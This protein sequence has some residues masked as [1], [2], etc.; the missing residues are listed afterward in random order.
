[1]RPPRRVHFLLLALACTV[2][3]W[4]ALRSPQP[5]PTPQPT[6]RSE[7]AQS[8][9]ASPAEAPSPAPP[10]PTPQAPAKPPANTPPQPAHIAAQMASRVDS[11][12]SAAFYHWAE[13]YL[14]A[15]EHERAALVEEGRQLAEARRPELRAVIVADPRKA[16][17]HAV[18]MVLRQNLPPAVLERLEDRH[19]AIGVLRVLQGVPMAGDP[20][21]PRSLT[22]R[23]VE[24]KDGGTY[25]AYVYGRRSEV[26]TW[27]ANASLNGISIDRQLALNENPSRTLEVGE[28]PPPEKPSVTI[29]PVSGLVTPGASLA[30]GAPITE[31]TPAV[32]TATQIVQL[33]GQY[34]VETYNQTILYGEGVTGGSLGFTGI[35]PAAPTP[36][37]GVVRVLA[38]PMTYADQNGVPST[39][40]ALYNVLRDVGDFYAKASFG[41]LTLVGTVTPP[42]KLAHN[43][44]WYVNR[45]TTNGGDISGTSL[46]HSHARDEARKLGFDSNN[47]DCIVVRHNGGPGSYGGLAGGSTVWMRSDSTGTWAHEIGHCFGLGHSNSWDTAGTSAIGAGTNLEYGDTY[48]I[49]GNSGSFPAGHYNAQAKSQIKW[50]PP[51]FIESIAQSGQYR[52]YAFDQ[53]VL[54]PGRRYALTVTKDSQKTYWGELRSLFDTNPWAKNGVLLGWRYPNGSGSNLQRI[55]VTPGSPFSQSDAPIAVGNTFSDLETGIHMTTIAVNDTPRY[56]DVV[57]NFGDFS[58]NRPP[59]LSLTASAEVVPLGATV[60]FTASASDPDNDA[61]AYY[62][63]HFGDTSVKLVS[64]N[65]PVITRTFSTAGSYVVSC[66]VSDMKGGTSTRSRLITVGTGNS[67][68]TISGRITLMG[69]GL[70]DVV[71]TA[72]GSNGVVTDAD[73]SYSIP[74]L[75]ANTYTMTPLLYGYSFGELFN[76]SIT[77]SP[78]A[79]GADFEASPLP[80]VTIAA[81]IPTA[82]ELAPVTTGRFT[83]T[84]TGDTTQSLVVNV[85]TALGSATKTSDYTLSPD[86]V[87]ASQGFS[88]FTIPA[89]SATL[90]I[91]VTPV[92]DTSAE[93]PETVILQLGPGNGY[94]VGKG[95]SATVVIEDDDTALPKISITATR[96]TTQEGSSQQGL[97]TITR[98]GATTT[99]LTVLYSVGGTATAGADYTTL[100]GTL[101][102]PAGSASA[103]I[104]VVPVDDTISEPLETISLTLSTNAAYL[105]DPLAT[106]ATVNL[107]DNDLQ[108][109][110]VVATD[111]TATEVDLTVPGAVPDT[112]TFVITRSGDTSN[113]LT[114]YYAMT[115]TPSTGVAALHGV[116]YE[117]LP[118]S[119]IIPAGSTQASIT[120]LPR[121]DNM[122]EGPESVVLSLGAGTT[123]YVLGS[124][125]SATVTINDAPTD[126]PT[127]DVVNTSSASEPSTT[128]TFRITVRGGTGTGTLPIAF[129]LG[130]TATFTTDYTVTGTG[131]TSTGTSV[132][133]S[134]GATV[135]KDV[136]ITP[137]NDTTAEELETIILT[138]TP[139]AS[140]TTY[141][142]TSS[143][144]MWLKDDDQPTVFVDT[145]VGTSGSSTVTEGTTSTPT[146]F[147]VSR[148]G[149]TTAALVVN[150]TIGGT[151]TAG[152]DYTAL[153]GTVTIA[154]GSLGADVPVVITNDTTF[155]GVETITFDF[156]PGAYARGPGAV[157]YIADNETSTQTVAF[158]SA[159]ASG[160]E[161]VATVNIPVTLA[162][163]ATQR[164]TVEYAADSGTRSAVTATATVSPVPYWLRMV[165][166][167]TSFTSYHSPDGVTWTQLG[168]AQTI[169]MSSTSYLA[170]LAVTSHV[171][172]TLC[173]VV[174]DNVTV[175]GLANGGTQGASSTA[176]IGTV[177]ATGSATSSSGTYSISG[178]GADITGTGDA[179]RYLW[180]PIT[181]STTCTLTARV[182]SQTNTNTSARAAVMI[183]EST[184]TGSMHAMTA[185]MPSN[186]IG[187]F[188]RATTN[189]TATNPSNFT[190]TSRPS[191]LR[192]DRAGDVF[193]TSISR[194]GVSWAQ[195]GTPQTLALPPT[196]LA[197][198]AVSAKSDGSFTTATFDQLTLNGSTAG[199]LNGR[200]IGFV[201]EEGSYS[202]SNGVHTVVGSGAGINTSTQDECYFPAQSVTGDFS[203]AARIT[204]LTGGATTAQ[205]GIMVREDD[206]YR[207][208][209]VYIG[210]V[211]TAS[212]ESIA[213][214]TS[215][216]TAFGSGVDFTLNAGTL[217]FEVGEQTKNITLSITDD[218]AP[219]PGDNIVLL[220]RNPTAAI[221]GAL[222]QF[223]YTIIDND[224][225]TSTPFVAF[226][227]GTS[228][229]NESDGSAS[230]LVSLS[231][232]A[233]SIITVAYATANGSATAGA[234]YQAAAGTLSFA[235]GETLKAIPAIPILQDAVSEPDETLLVTLSNPSGAQLG[236]ITTHTLTINDDDFPTVNLTASDP[237]A[238]EAGDTGTFT[239]ARTGSLS[240]ALSVG[241]T[242]SGTATSGT[243]YAAIATPGTVL[244]PDGQATATVT[245]TPIQ[246]TT[247]EGTETVILTLS[248][249]ASNYKLGTATSATVSIADDDRSTV[250]IVANIPLASEDAG[251]PGQFTITRT[252]PLGVALTV[253][254]TVSGTATSTTDYTTSPTTIT[255]L[256]FSAG[257]ASRTIDILPVDD[258]L[259]EPSE[260]VTISLGTGSYDIGANSFASVEITDNDAQ[261]SLF[262][263]GP[264]AQGALVAAGNGVMLSATVADDGKPQPLT[265]AWTQVA[266]PGTATFDNAAAASTGVTFDLPGTY[267]L[268][269]SATDGQFTVS[270][271]TTVVVGSAITAADWVTQDLGTSSSRRGQTLQL[272]STFSL[273]GTGA[274]YAATTN[275]QAHVALRSIDGDSSIVTRLTSLP[276]TTG[277]A[278]VTIRDAMVR[279]AR[280]AVLGYVPGTG[281]QFRTRTAVTT[282]D[283]VVTQTGLT[284]PLW[285]KLERNS[286][287]GAITASYAPDS[288]GAP[289]TWTTLGTPTVITMDTRANVGLTTTSNSTS[290]S[291][292]AT[293]DNVTLTPTPA[294]PALIAEDAAATPALAGN[295]SLTAGT[296]T[297]AGS[298]NGY[299][300]AWQYSGDLM[301]TAKHA[302][303]T[304]SAGSATSGIRIS[305]NI[306]GGAYAQVGRIP[307]GSYSG[308]LWRSVAGGTPAG[309]PSFTGATRW[310]RVIRKGN[311]ITAFH[312]ADVSG[313]P[314]T[315]TQI[316][317]PQTVIMTT[318][319]LV[320]F[321]VDNASGV[322]LNTV[323]FSNLSIVPLNSA[324][325][326][327]IQSLA[328]NAPSPVALDGTVT[329][330]NYPT[331][332]NL[333]TLWSQR[334][335]PAT[336]RF[337]SSTSVDSLANLPKT[338]SYTVRLAADDG[339]I[340]SFR[341]LTLTGIGDAA[342][343]TAPSLGAMSIAGSE[344]TT[345]TF[346][347][348]PFTT[349]YSDPNGDALFSITI[350]SLP[351]T[352]ILKF[353]GTAVTLNQVIPIANIGNLTYTP[354]LNEYGAK[355]FTLTAFDG[356]ASS[357]PA[358][359]TMNIAAVN[360]VPTANTRFLTTVE[361]TAYTGTLTGFDIE[362]DPLTFS[363]ATQGS[364]G[365]ATITN[366]ATGAFIYTPNP[367]ANGSDSFTFL[368]NDGTATSAP[369]T[370]SV[371]I[372]PVNDAPLA[373]SRPITIPEDTTFTGTLIGSDVDGDAISFS[374]LTQPSKG[375]AVITNAATGDFTYT[376]NPNANGS[377]SFTFLVSDGSLTSAPATVSFTIT[378]VNDTPV[379]NAQPI[380]TNEDTAFT[381]TLTGSDIDGDPLTFSVVTQGTKGTVAITDTSTGAFTYTPNADANGSDSFTFK[382]NDGTANSAPATVSVTITPVNDAPVANPRSITTNENTAF[383]GFLTGSDAESDP[384]TFSIVT[385]GSKGTV[386]IRK[387]STG[388]FTYTPNPNAYGS[389]SFTFEIT[390]GTENSATATVAVTITPAPSRSFSGWSNDA[391]L[392]DS[393]LMKY[394]I[395]GAA[396]PEATGQDPITTV[397]PTAF[398]I[399]AV[400]RTNSESLTVVAEAVSALSDYATPSSTLTIQGIAAADQ[401]G[402]PGGCQRQIFTANSTGK[403]R[404]FLRLKV[405]LAP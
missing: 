283:T 67:R 9:T 93:G 300:H 270:D 347:P 99:A 155:E 229:V 66:T 246:D 290:A 235:P 317:Q 105:I 306:E 288:A 78:S 198:F 389:D 254:L 117:A 89:D 56:A 379:A 278:G 395:G 257:Q 333:T 84:R 2:V 240:G 271:Q 353:S 120:I 391:T 303:A 118:G 26:V 194:D 46:E 18:P 143:A 166:N 184:A 52:L 191:W 263:T 322:G 285:L 98:T 19:N 295:S 176:D 336:I 44:A 74:N 247:N 245:V 209:M 275:D 125:S 103:T 41:R 265:L 159:G 183:R 40:A 86:Y 297:V 230:V 286:T 188:A 79:S 318:P 348:T 281:L 31:E 161:S 403:A 187:I 334:A 346:T 331:P 121:F 108:T 212:A 320:G 390:D 202:L 150:Y 337:S 3:F 355:T 72:N 373:T 139:S 152:S 12:A 8:T 368:A 163:P 252:E 104:S 360:D 363:I 58:S 261:P 386:A 362:G 14:S 315:W 173:A 294:A 338:G 57:V 45:D 133:L 27:T 231:R 16:L 137:V 369:G 357:T 134:N 292:T 397:T 269:L 253:N 365:I 47:Y 370:V 63:Q 304:S 92:V 30:E 33:C 236:A 227:S 179:F 135:T 20:T 239:F 36:A 127:V 215:V 203:I 284:L 311:S 207:G 160:L 170:G 220:L 175:T 219:E 330:D 384:L 305:E 321:W 109:I 10:Q 128:G 319:V 107:I 153:S 276:L 314:G 167:G 237:N 367:N 174:F 43:E 249:S 113:P 218:N 171:A 124:P 197:G 374:L 225:A 96:D 38:I 131:N 326:V 233:S 382:T 49:M 138:L 90:D 401:S 29:C 312:A 158:Q 180:F 148:T 241:F 340:Q 59:T 242:R 140:Y 342:L 190:P 178:A 280:R 289:G 387:A 299:F 55:D 62:W 111:P 216:S 339:S 7:I 69:V 162:S 258:L 70:P 186:S 110:T 392:T 279:S 266:G 345:L 97:F 172:G 378:P 375:I 260:F 364:K 393:L 154:A 115:G 402:V 116:D 293:F 255:T 71:V 145:Q 343:N 267:I 24:F 73:G 268:Q 87:N 211:S 398:T 222:T 214:T 341:D 234:D 396:T 282:N 206:N 53:G 141:P 273:T 244:I 404:K 77:V 359:L 54:V 21:P 366:A 210:S 119:V 149:S 88:T 213:R 325:V 248:A 250:S 399:T 349:A 132:T 95:S 169:S 238:N 68:Y 147:Y 309:V 129:T 224:A 114:V 83:L 50:L 75:S 405:Q 377:D 327:S 274:G 228:S 226:A 136:V 35:L 177:G 91:T 400:V 94:L 17:E 308:F 1:M 251:H 371:T 130:G 60:T 23:E 287:T 277:L 298:T 262:I 39:E 142:P 76:N 376:P 256:V 264:G 385:Q 144:T 157:M 6:P 352:G 122:G 37:L 272:G 201:N 193:T 221:L 204:S 329:D 82:K 4:L 388:A 13:R 332:P 126:L 11:P 383:S 351:S 25:R 182:V 48:D 42:V 205:A 310:I 189:G 350:T 372:T 81:S 335:G 65:T 356:I 313:A 232:P 156:A 101:L 85:N 106:N 217:T 123:N 192:L 324:P 5:H 164:V 380:T 208:R 32:E 243:D 80:V 358:T 64:G 381:G 344:D 302:T 301:V 223:T 328:A 199:T 291:T 181:N 323:T 185:V 112:G 195:V 316:G 146:K 151:A 102:I 168:T 22:F 15:P 259:T 61:L 296:Y 165:R 196:L 34:H 361:D 100:P 51:A 394:A 307:T 354:A 28:V 200:T